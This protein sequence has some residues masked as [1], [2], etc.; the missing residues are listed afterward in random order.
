MAEYYTP[1]FHCFNIIHYVYNLLTSCIKWQLYLSMISQIKNTM[2]ILLLKSKKERVQNRVMWE[3]WMLVREVEYKLPDWLLHETLELLSFRCHSSMFM[4]PT[5]ARNTKLTKTYRVWM[6][7]NKIWRLN[8][9]Y[10]N[11][12]QWNP[13]AYWGILWKPILYYIGKS[14]INV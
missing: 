11:R 4:L 8:G 5:R 9:V 13:T 7:I 2:N 10:L 6:Q 1:C 12:Y 3:F 14:R